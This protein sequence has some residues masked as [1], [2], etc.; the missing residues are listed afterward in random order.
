MSRTKQQTERQT[1]GVITREYK[2]LNLE[3]P[4]PTLDGFL[5][6]NES[7]YVRN[8]F[9]EIPEV[10]EKKWKLKIEGAIENSLEIG[11]EELLKMPSE[12]VAVTL[13]CAGNSRI[14]LDP[15]ADGVQWELGAVGTAEWTGVPLKA[16]LERAGVRDSAVEVVLEGADRGEIKDPPKTPGE[17]SFSRSLPI[18]K[19]LT[20]NIL[21][22][23]EMNGERLAPEH[24]FPVRAVVPGW[25]G[26]AWVKWLERIVVTEE[27]F[28]GFFQTADY[29]YWVKEDGLPPQMIP[30]TEMQVKSEIARP[31]MHETV[32]A[33]S[34][35]K[36]KGAAWSGDAK[37]SKVEISTDG[38]KKWHEAKLTGEARENAWQMW[39]FEW[40][41]PAKTGK[42][43]L[44]ARA[45]DERGRVQ[46][47][48]HAEGRGGYLVN[49]TLPVG[50]EVK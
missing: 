17:I 1:A 35:Y 26:M 10:E 38:G 50:I 48:E 27:P 19:A 29:S 43:T 6:P 45:T 33:N 12:T 11:Y 3:F 41:V 20:D 36:I 13:E 30:I 9:P 32:A 8:H 5:T 21:L 40:E 49:H 46:P 23:Y 14:F 22:A 25:Y 31:A 42:H 24:G 18:E 16:I 37:V 4:F 44:M 34:I 47:S 2:P 7:F 28:T 15:K 39:E